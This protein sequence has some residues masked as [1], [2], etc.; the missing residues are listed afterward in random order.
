MRVD[1]LVWY[2]PVL[3]DG[4]RYFASRMDRPSAYGGVHPGG[5]TENSLLSLGDETYVEI[6]ARDPR[7]R[8][9][10]SLD[11]EL[12]GLDGQGLY[13]WAV[14][15]VDLRTIVDHALR[16]SYAV[17]DI[18]GGGRRLPDG[19]WLG[20][21]CVGLHSHAFGALVPFFIDWSGSA[22]PAASAPRGGRL[23]KIELFSPHADELNRLFQT[24]GLD[25]SASRRNKPGIT[26]T[27]ET[28]NGSQQLTSF[29]PVPR[30][31][32]I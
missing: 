23:S 3:A 11:S 18:V 27:L 17:S 8:A 25:F 10:A 12:A 26:V 21:E 1:H 4:E 28:R 6:L 7:Q 16:A 13:H 9:T 30:G 32:I 14:G 22:H 24:L 29:D 31:F 15:G 19:S 2:S 5:G 20:W